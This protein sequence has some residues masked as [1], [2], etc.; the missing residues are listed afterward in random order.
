M[1]RFPTTCIMQDRYSLP[2]TDTILRSSPAMRTLIHLF[3]SLAAVPLVLPEQ[4]T[5]TV[6]SVIPGGRAISELAGRLE[7]QI[8][9]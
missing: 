3:S 8:V 9:V 1:F 5:D 7:L 6:S 4:P 2:I